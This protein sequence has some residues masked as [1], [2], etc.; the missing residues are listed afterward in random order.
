MK[1]KLQ[2]AQLKKISCGRFAIAFRNQE[3][4]SVFFI[5]GGVQETD[6]MRWTVLLRQDAGPDKAMIPY[7]LDTFNTA[8]AADITDQ[9]EITYRAEDLLEASITEAVFAKDMPGALVLANNRMLL[10]FRNFVQG[11]QFITLLTDL[12]TGLTLDPEAVQD[13]RGILVLRWAIMI[14]GQNAYQQSE[15]LTQFP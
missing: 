7:H 2:F 5:A 13:V 10:A 6:P 11:N 3:K 4:A 1:G 15:V 9:V 12:E 8:I 14:K